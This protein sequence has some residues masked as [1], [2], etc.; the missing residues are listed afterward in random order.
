MK[1]KRIL[2]KISAVLLVVAIVVVSVVYYVLQTSVSYG[3][4]PFSYETG[5]LRTIDGKY[6][7]DSGS[8]GTIFSER[9]AKYR[10]IGR[11][12][13]TDC[14]GVS[15]QSPYYYISQIEVQ[16]NLW[17]KNIF[18]SIAPLR[19]TYTDNKL[20]G[21][22]GMD[23]ISRANWHFS[24]KDSVLDIMD[25]HQIMNVP[26]SAVELQYYR[27]KYPLVSVKIEDFMVD[28]VLIDFGCFRDFCFTTEYIQRVLKQHP[29][30]RPQKDS[31]NGSFSSQKVKTYQFNKLR[32]E[33]M[34]FL[35]LTIDEF[36]KNLIGGAFFSRFDHLFWDSR[37]KK[38]YLWNEEEK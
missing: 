20:S 16:P 22:L 2:V 11:A 27:R 31:V 29:S 14:N 38:V 9:N 17:I 34:C 28:S 35:N 18:C 13:S 12:K 19:D 6:I 23:V 24:F 10:R 25:L 30:I 33:D 3:K 32:V 26:Y 15:V 36:T 21:I 1:A 4:Y 5:M 8:S 7:F 37:H